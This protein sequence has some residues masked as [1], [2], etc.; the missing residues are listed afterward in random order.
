MAARYKVV[1]GMAVYEYVSN[2]VPA[3]PKP[4]T[5]PKKKKK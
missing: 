1:N 4:E 3:Q 2:D 5:K